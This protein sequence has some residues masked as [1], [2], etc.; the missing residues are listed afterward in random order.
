[1][2]PPVDMKFVI[3]VSLK[4]KSRF[5]HFQGYHGN[6]F[7]THGNFDFELFVEK[8]TEKIVRN[9]FGTETLQILT[10]GGNPVSHGLPSCKM[11]I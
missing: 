5:Y 11:G 7:K 1:M 9:G 10:V 2:C 4:P 3:E 6:R 8:Y